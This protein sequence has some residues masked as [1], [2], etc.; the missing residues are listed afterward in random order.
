MFA[1]PC[2]APVEPWNGHMHFLDGAS[3]HRKVAIYTEQQSIEKYAHT[4]RPEAMS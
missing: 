2:V 1:F 3:A 4:S